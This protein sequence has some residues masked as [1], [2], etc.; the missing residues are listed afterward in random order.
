[1]YLK[2]LYKTVVLKGFP[3]EKETNQL[4]LKSLKFHDKTQ[5]SRIGVRE[6]SAVVG[7]DTLFTGATTMNSRVPDFQEVDL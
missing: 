2:R 7:V 3:L 1:M 6:V 4:E 5:M